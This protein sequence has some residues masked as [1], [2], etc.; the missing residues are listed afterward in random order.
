MWF[1]MGPS[2][3]ERADYLSNPDNVLL[4]EGLSSHDQRALAK[5]FSQ[6][7]ISEELMRDLARVGHA[8]INQ[9]D[10]LGAVGA[11]SSTALTELPIAESKIDTDVWE[12]IGS[13]LVD[14]ESSELHPSPSAPRLQDL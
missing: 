1:V 2:R 6:G 10:E 11:E 12:R 7:E 14:F 4:C 13:I 8:G 3:S 5:A 9:G